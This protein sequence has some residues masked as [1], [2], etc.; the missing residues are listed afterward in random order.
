MSEAAPFIEEQEL[1]DQ[2]EVVVESQ[3]VQEN[4][5]EPKKKSFLSE[6]L[7]PFTTR[8]FWFEMLSA[9]ARQAFASALYAFGGVLL[10]YGKKTLDRTFY[11]EMGSQR[12][13][14]DQA[15]QK[16]FSGQGF[17]PMP[18]YHDDFRPNRYNMETSP[19]NRFPGFGH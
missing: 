17:A 15:A 2:P 18:T 5:I 7:G 4:E 16:A 1:N 8:R 6:F 13:G 10:E 11:P 9:L 12:T 19:G 3:K 14:G